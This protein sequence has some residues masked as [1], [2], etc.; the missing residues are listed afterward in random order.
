MAFSRMEKWQR[1][2]SIP[3]LQWQRYHAYAMGLMPTISVP[4]QLTKI[5]SRVS[6][7]TA[8]HTVS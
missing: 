7:Y 4:I 8:Q 5:M 2:R 1:Y 6:I 3:D